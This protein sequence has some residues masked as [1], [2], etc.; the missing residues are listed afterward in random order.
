[1]VGDKGIDVRGTFVAA[2]VIR[3]DM[4]IQVKRHGN[5]IGAPDVRSLRGSLDPNERGL[6]ITTSRF[7]KGAREKATLAN[8]QPIGLIDGEELVT[9]LVQYEIGVKRANPDLLEAA[10]L[11]TPAE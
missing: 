7:A 5:N 3:T 8:R 9:L 2:G 10:R 6:F 11:L 4:A 1:V